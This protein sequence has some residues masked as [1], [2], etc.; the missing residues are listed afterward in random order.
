[1]IDADKIKPDIKSVEGGREVTFAASSDV[2]LHRNGWF[3]SYLEKLEHTDDAVD[4]SFI[5]QG[6]APILY[7]HCRRISDIAGKING[8]EIRN[9]RLYVRAFFADDIPEQKDAADRIAAGAITA[10]SVGWDYNPADVDVR[11]WE[12]MTTAEKDTGAEYAVDY[13]KWK[14]MEVSLVS[15]PADDTVGMGRGMP[16][17]SYTRDKDITSLARE[18]LAMRSQERDNNNKKRSS[19]MNDED[20]KAKAKAAEEEA[21]TENEEDVEATSKEADDTSDDKEDARKRGWAV[22]DEHKELLGEH[23]AD[24][25]KR[26]IGE[27]W[28]ATKARAVVLDT[29]KAMTKDVPARTGALTPEKVAIHLDKGQNDFSI[30]RYA[31]EALSGKLKS[32]LGTLEAEMHTDAERARTGPALMANEFALPARFLFSD[33]RFV[34]AAM[35]K[36]GQ[37]AIELGDAGGTDGASAYA[38]GAFDEMQLIHALYARQGILPMVSVF[39]ELLTSSLEIPVEARRSDVGFATGESTTRNDT[40]EPTYNETLRWE[41]HE[42][43]GQF[44]VS[45]RLTDQTTVLFDRIMQLLTEDIP[46]GINRAI[47]T[48]QTQQGVAGGA[49]APQGI[50]AD[51][52]VGSQVIPAA[53]RVAPAAAAQAFAVADAW[54]VVNGLKTAVESA[55]AHYNGEGMYFMNSAM[56]G[57]LEETEKFGDSSGEPILKYATMPDGSLVGRIA[58]SKVML[59]NHIPDTFDGSVAG[60]ATNKIKQSVAAATSAT[61]V[62]SANRRNMLLY[63][64]PQEVKVGYFSDLTMIVDPYSSKEK[65]RG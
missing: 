64:I 1:M 40:E 65:R 50:Y 22:I 19:T 48:G 8:Y 10:V 12:H 27:G 17:A 29:M 3:G 23:F 32:G 49:G 24:V 2:Q 41:W 58:G 21:E 33:K 42:V 9:G 7:D 60:A 47:L 62:T 59:D 44:T 31:R 61:A 13:R 55:N 37:R 6:D 20:K 14:P 63:C 39:P 11:D 5:R 43:Y 38:N 34:S 30:A 26:A 57:R 45:R 51:V 46:R 52:V 53:N 16:V 56:K 18:R 54:G 28:T 36:S 15:I 25:R 4:A 35:R